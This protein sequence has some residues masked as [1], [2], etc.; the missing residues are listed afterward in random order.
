MVI[1]ITGDGKGKTTSSIGQAVRAIGQGKR[2]AMFQFIKS[3]TYPSGEDEILPKVFG[4][5][6]V[7]KKGGRGFVGILDD[8][9]PRSVHKKAA[10]QTLEWG[11]KAIKSKKYDLVILDEI[12]VALYL[13]LITKKE[14]KELIKSIPENMDVILTGRHASEEFIKRADL[15]TECREIKHPYTKGAKAKKGVEY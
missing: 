5:K 14:V 11:R 2:V 15:V 12:W 4:K 9:L 3:H 10:E 13:K 6:F 1:I 7:Y 8:K